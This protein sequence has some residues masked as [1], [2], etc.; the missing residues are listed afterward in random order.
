MTREALDTNLLVYAEL[1]SD[2][3]KGARSTDLILRSARDG[4]TPVQ[5]LELSD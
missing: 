2:P 1:E 4:V 5:V 3:E